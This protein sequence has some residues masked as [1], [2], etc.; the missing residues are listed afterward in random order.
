MAASKESMDAEAEEALSQIDEKMYDAKLLD[1]GVRRI[2]KYAMVFYG[3]T[4]KVVKKG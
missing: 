1:A 3:K 4:V 2:D